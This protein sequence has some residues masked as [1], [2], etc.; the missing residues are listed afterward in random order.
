MPFHILN[1]QDYIINK[2]VYIVS[3]QYPQTSSHF[4]RQTS[5]HNVHRF[6]SASRHPP[7][8]S[9]RRAC[10]TTAKPCLPESKPKQQGISPSSPGRPRPPAAQARMTQACSSQGW[11]VQD[12]INYSSYRGHSSAPQGSTGRHRPFQPGKPRAPTC[13]LLSPWALR[14]ALPPARECQMAHWS[15]LS[16]PVESTCHPKPSKQ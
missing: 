3:T 12:L 4:I 9:E 10:E 15:T 1:I 16:D 2:L 11:M 14:L 8:S 6:K 13:S 7:T 5:H